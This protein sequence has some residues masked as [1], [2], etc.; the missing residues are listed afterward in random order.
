MKGVFT[1]NC[2]RVSEW[3]TTFPDGSQNY[4]GPFDHGFGILLNVAIGGWGGAPDDSLD[5]HL[6]SNTFQVD[7]VRVFADRA[8]NPG[9]FWQREL[10][11]CSP[12]QPGRYKEAVG[13]ANCSA[14]PK[15]SASKLIGAASRE[16]CVLCLTGF[17]SPGDQAECEECP[18]GKS[19]AETNSSQCDPCNAG[20]ST[21]G[22]FFYRPS[23]IFSSPLL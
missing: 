14:C 18:V 2:Y 8:C 3:F 6:I 1:N 23:L 12:C 15:G 20:K 5:A 10:L 21:K 19:A 16:T 9:Q 11:S 17:S 7:F 4:P 22:V 13:P